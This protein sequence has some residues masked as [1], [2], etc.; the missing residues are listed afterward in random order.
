MNG[1]LRRIGAFLTALV[2]V[3]G[4]VPVAFAETA[5]VTVLFTHDLHSHL[6]PSAK[7]GGGEYGG[8][9]RLM[10]AIQAERA[11]APDAI[12]VDGG[13]FSMGSLFQT[14]YPTAATELRIMG[15]M[16][17]DATTFG[18]H[19]FDYLQAG[20]AGMLNAAVDSGDPLPALLNC[21]YLPPT[22]ESEEYDELDAAVWEAMERYGV[23]DYTLIE[24]G[25][26][27]FAIF[28]VYG[29]NSVECSPQSGMAFEEPAVA[30]QRTVDAAVA[31]CVAANGV[32]PIVIALSHGGTSGGAGEDV[33]LAN[34]VT[35]IDLIVSGHTHTTLT[36][37]IRVGETCIVSA[38]EYGKNLGV[39]TLRFD[40]VQAELAEYRLVPI[41]ETVADEP[42]IA[43]LVERLKSDVQENYLDDYGFG[44]DEVLV[45]N[46]YQ[47]DT[48][49]ETKAT[50]H[51]STLGSL[52]AD[53][54]KWAVEE[55]TGEPVDVAL[56]ASGVIRE[57]V[58]VGDVTVSD[59]FN[60][61]S[62]GVGTEGELV[63]IWLTGKDLMNALEVDASVYP[64][65]HSA[66]LFFGGVEYSFNTS[67]MIFNKVDYAMLRRNDGTLEK[68]EPDKLYRVVTGMYAG[69]MLGNV[70]DTSMGLLT[71]TPRDAAGNAIDRT[72]FADYVVRNENGVPVKEWYAIASYLDEMDGEMDAAY[73]QT[74]GRKVIYSSL[75]PVKLLKNANK[76]TYGLLGVLLLLVLLVTVVVR[77][78]RRIIRKRK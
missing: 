61:A 32:E 1:F 25:G 20:L 73:S 31:E 35:G 62:L 53:A 72:K 46:P 68:I 58:P 7:E 12:L 40:G 29:Y 9:A 42:Q 4:M 26:A 36:E 44:F 70:E 33:D 51:E 11:K 74:D 37:P 77:T 63:S 38:G 28:G 17:Y 21:N 19:E 69:Q 14:A 18:N 34:A 30:A 71:I 49:P 22:A 64:L 16:G 13:D 10:T 54:Y 27:W 39:V 65:M 41:D 56:T 43:D 23:K 76:F 78:I 24:R 52:F 15:A 57:S 5:E 75:N 45:N 59:I 48:A 66:Q 47:F 60:A 50:A 6:L 8:Y 67:R 3:L 55:A 2:L